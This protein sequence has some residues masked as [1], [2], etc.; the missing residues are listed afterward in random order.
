MDEF[1]KKL[2]EEDGIPLPDDL[3]D[4]A[5]PPPPPKALTPEE[6]AEIKR[7]QA[8]ETKEKRADITGRHTQW[9]KKLTRVGE[10][11]LQDLMEK[12]NGMRKSVVD[13]M[14]TKPEMFNLL[15][16]MQEEG[17]KQ[18]EKTDKYLQ[19]IIK[20]GKKD[21][22]VSSKWTKVVAKVQKGLDTRTI[23]TTTYLQNWYR[24]VMLKEKEVV[25]FFVVY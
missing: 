17:F 2:F 18:V 19:K 15:K 7:L 4:H 24:D 14:R 11:E 25:S 6:E 8:I 10:E 12:V 16:T 13:N 5:T 22:E 23:E 9:E 3:K 1:L 20:E 21:E